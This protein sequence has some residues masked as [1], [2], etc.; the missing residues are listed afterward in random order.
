ML[1]FDLRIFFMGGQFIVVVH[2]ETGQ[3]RAIRLYAGVLTSGSRVTTKQLRSYP[4]RWARPGHSSS[5]SSQLIQTLKRIALVPN[6][7]PSPHPSF[8]NAHPSFQSSWRL[9]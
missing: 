7:H 1:T 3:R 5:D 6:S 8:P 4:G 2:I 9:A